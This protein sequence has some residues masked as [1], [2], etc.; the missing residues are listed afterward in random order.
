M[1]NAA[2]SPRFSLAALTVLE[3]SPPE[4][5]AVAAE[6]GYDA[7]GLRLIPATPEEHH[8]PLANDKLLLRRTQ[9]ALRDTGIKVLDI[10]I[11]RLKPETH[12]V[13]EFA[14]ILDTGAELGASEVLVAG[15]DEDLVRTQ[16]NFAQLCELAKSR[17]LHPHLEFMPWT[18]VKNLEQ[19]ARV[20]GAMRSRGIDNACLLV[21]AFHFN[22]SASRLETLANVPTEWLRYVQL[23]DVVGS[24][25]SDMNEILRQARQ[26]R[27]FPGDGDIELISLLHALPHDIPISLEIPTEGLRQQGVSALER[28]QRALTKTRELLAAL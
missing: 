28:A 15:N 19:A 25:P 6:A 17:G 21:D 10:E 13:E 14:H 3:L 18:G 23:C 4:M 20:V 9:Q 27:C 26:E 1:P 11:L 12:I 7:V 16:D 8:F 24:I 2:L 22:R 5:I